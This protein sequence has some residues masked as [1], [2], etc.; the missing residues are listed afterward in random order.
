MTRVLALFWRDLKVSFAYT[1]RT[2]V[3]RLVRGMDKLS[4]GMNSIRYRHLYIIPLLV[5]CLYLFYCYTSSSSGSFASEEHLQINRN[6]Y[7]TDKSHILKQKGCIYDTKYPLSSIQRTAEGIRYH[8]G[9]IADL[10]EERSKVAGKKFTWQSYLK[11]GYLT[12]L[13]NGKYTV[14]WKDKIT[15]MTN[16]NEKGRGLELSE[17]CVFNGKLYT[18]DDRTGLVYQILKDQVIPWII[19]MDGD[20]LSK[21]GFKGEWMTVKDGTL[22]VGGLGKEWTTKSGTFINYHPLFVKSIDQFGAVAHHNWTNNYLRIRAK[23]GIR[24]PGYMIHEAVMW[25]SI[26]QR[27]YFLPRRMSKQK[28][29][30]MSDER[31]GTNVLISAT[32]DFTDIKVVYVGNVVPTHGFSSFKFVP[33]TDDNVAVA[34]KTMEVGS[35]ISTYIMAFLVDTGEVVMSEK[36]IANNKYEGIEFI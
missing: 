24:F 9:V 30:D 22:Y 33:N 19:L 15:M 31:R 20:G 4:Q 28:Y 7:S 2:A 6:C 29:D 34:L 32:Q 3:R 27:W 12:K 14:E 1:T 21:K 36:L 25:S 23:V 11:T 10:D 16:L 13:N 17:L 18:V 26:K 5:L 35:N 8:I